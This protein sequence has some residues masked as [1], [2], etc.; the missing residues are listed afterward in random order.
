MSAWGTFDAEAEAYERWE[1]EQ[2]DRGE[3]ETL[4]EEY[5]RESV[6]TDEREPF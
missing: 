3:H 1:N 6:R 2:E 4:V 5:E